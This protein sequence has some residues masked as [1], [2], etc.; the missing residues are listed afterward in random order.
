MLV[1]SLIASTSHN[2]NHQPFHQPKNSN[3][4]LTSGSPL[5][6]NNTSNIIV[7][8]IQSNSD[9]PTSGISMNL[10]K[11]FYTVGDWVGIKGSVKNLIEG[12]NEIR[13]DLHD[14]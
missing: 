10:D 8:P 1:S 14:F 12:K 5:Q 3:S 4:S 2:L 11:K 6:T 7:G 13:T 9:A